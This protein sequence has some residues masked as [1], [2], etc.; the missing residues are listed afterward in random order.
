MPISRL[1]GGVVRTRAAGRVLT[2]SRVGIRV[3]YEVHK[4]EVRQAALV[5]RH[6]DA[7]L[8]RKASH[9]QVAG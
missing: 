8:I 9:E 2:A 6:G 5:D 7:R 3:G 1:L 4:V